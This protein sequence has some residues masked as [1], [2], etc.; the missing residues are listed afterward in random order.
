MTKKKILIIGKNG[1]LAGAIQAEVGSFGFEVIAFDRQE[2]DVTNWPQVKK[3][4][5]K[6]KPDILINTS[7]LQVVLQCEE[8][9][10]RAMEVNFLAI[11]NLARECKERN[12]IF[13]TY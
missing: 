3:I 10:Q 2:M 1:Q 8:N 11:Q 9:P 13:V 6:I 7:D 12:I 4:L 5:D